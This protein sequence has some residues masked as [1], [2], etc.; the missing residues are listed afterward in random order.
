MHPVP[1]LSYRL[2]E[3]L[4]REQAALSTTPGT[5]KELE[6]MA[7]E[8]AAL[9]DRLERQPPKAARSRET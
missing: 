3:L 9:A 7:S 1:D 2:L 4:C 6:R 5:R 8:Y